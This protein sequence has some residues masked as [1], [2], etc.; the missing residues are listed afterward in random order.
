MSMP[1]RFKKGLWGGD[2]ER[3]GNTSMALSR[4]I[5]GLLGHRF[6]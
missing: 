5:W 4:V 2:Q 1:F 3:V 6:Y